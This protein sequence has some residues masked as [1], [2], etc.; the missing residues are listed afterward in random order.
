MGQV[1]GIY[2]RR[3]VRKY[4][5]EELQVGILEEVKEASRGVKRLYEDIDMDIHILEDGIRFQNITSGIIG[6]LGKIIAPH[7]IVVTSEKKEGYLE[8]SGFALEEIVLDLGGLGIGT[9][10]IGRGINHEL[11][12]SMIPI[13]KNHEVVFV[14]SFGYPRSEE[15]SRKRMLRWKKRM[16]ITEFA[17]GHLTRTWRHILDAV[18]M[19]PVAM[20]TRPWKFHIN[21]NRVDIYS[22]NRKGIFNWGSPKMNRIA[23]GAALYHIYMA[24]MGLDKEIRIIQ[25]Q[26]NKKED[27]R[28]IASIVE[29][30][31]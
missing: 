8:N 12:K 9:C 25:L 15:S 2:G 14:L 1:A 20:N 4:L 22:M 27:C 5:N 31:E 13:K 10:F 21:D 3:S 16:E 26:D 7:Y 30:E 19:A 24:A 29:S 17:S 23:L 6:G 18:K 28:Y 11:L